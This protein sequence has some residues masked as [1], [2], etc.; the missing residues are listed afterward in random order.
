MNTPNKL[1]LLRVLLVPVFMFFMMYDFVPGARYIGAVIFI[2]ASLTDWLDGFLARKNNLVTNFGKIMDPLADK[3]LVT[4]ALLCLTA[5]GTASSWITLIIL[6]R[7]FIVS[8]IRIA[9]AAEGNVIAASWWGKIKT[10]WQMISIIIALVFGVNLFVTICLWIAAV[11]TVVSG[12]DYLAKNAKY[13]S[14]K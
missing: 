2:L 6:S 3:M 10:V 9:A 11:L 13:L 8:G 14:M 4:A 1:T 7:E 5:E 12:V